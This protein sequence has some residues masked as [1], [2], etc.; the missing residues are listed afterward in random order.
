MTS[1]HSRSRCVRTSLRG[2]PSPVMCS[3][4]ASPVPSATQKRS[5]NIAVR[6]AAAWAT[7]AGWYR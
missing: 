3:F 6:V 7:I 2:H 1:T 4:E 5:G